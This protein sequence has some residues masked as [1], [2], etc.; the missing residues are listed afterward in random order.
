MSDDSQGTD[1]DPRRQAAISGAA[2]IRAN[3]TNAATALARL[4]QSGAQR[5]RRF[6]QTGRAPDPGFTFANERTFL[7][8]NRTA[9]AMS[10]AGLAAAQFLKSH[11]HGLRLLI[12]A[13][14]HPRRGALVDELATLI[15]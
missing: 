8:W 9:F 3:A 10:A 6:D 1:A 13:A 15:A 4:L 12:R 14:N 2:D 11:L 7:A 5:E